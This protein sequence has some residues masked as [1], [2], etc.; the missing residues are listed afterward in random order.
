MFNLWMYLR[1]YYR[2]VSSGSPFVSDFFLHF[3][4]SVVVR[5]MT[6]QDHSLTLMLP[7]MYVCVLTTSSFYTSIIIKNH[8]KFILIIIRNSKGFRNV[9]VSQYFDDSLNFLGD[10]SIPKSVAAMHI[11]L[12]YNMY[13]MRAWYLLNTD[14]Q[15]SCRL[16]KGMEV[17]VFCVPLNFTLKKYNCHDLRCKCCQS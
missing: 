9:V 14:R 13:R 11:T 7:C 2:A 10:H 17:Y 3:T 8:R 16:H 4:K 15:L 1:K 6:T 12:T 5:S